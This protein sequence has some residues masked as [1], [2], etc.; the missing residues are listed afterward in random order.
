V[1]EDLVRSRN[2]H[3]QLQQAVAN[4]QTALAES[5]SA[6]KALDVQRVDL[7]LTLSSLLAD[8]DPAFSG[9][10]LPSDDWKD[11]W[12]AAPARF[13]AARQAEASQWLRQRSSYDERQQRLQ[14]LDIELRAGQDALSK[15]QRDAVQARVAYSSAEA[16][17][18]GLQ[19]QRLQLWG[20]KEA[21]AVE[22]ALN[23]AVTRH[24]SN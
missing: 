4:Q 17:L 13:Y 19:Q 16:R 6:A 9:S 24:A 2:A 12:R 7:A 18:Q 20:G 3:Q 1:Q 15:A 23:E 21:S 10:E 8:L 5:R 22:A 11:A 14:A